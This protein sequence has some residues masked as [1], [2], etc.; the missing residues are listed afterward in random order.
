M[1]NIATH[2]N[3]PVKFWQYRTQYITVTCVYIE[4]LIIQ[5]LQTLRIEYNI[6]LKLK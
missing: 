3:F 5:R 2:V 6:T 1:L 4:H